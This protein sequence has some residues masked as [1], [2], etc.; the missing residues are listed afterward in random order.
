MARSVHPGLLAAVALLLLAA[1][2]SAHGSHAVPKPKLQVHQASSPPPP[3]LPLYAR[4][5]YHFIFKL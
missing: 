5:H 3:P 4:T 1:Q 2:V